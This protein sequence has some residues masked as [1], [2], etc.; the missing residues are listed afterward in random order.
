[1]SRVTAED[2]PN[3]V[4]AQVSRS[5][6]L[7]LVNLINACESLEIPTPAYKLLQLLQKPEIAKAAIR[8]IDDARF[9]VV[10]ELPD[11]FDILENVDTISYAEA[12]S[13]VLRHGY[14]IVSPGITRMLAQD[15]GRNLISLEKS[16]GTGAPVCLQFAANGSLMNVC[17]PGRAKIEPECCIL[18]RK[19][20]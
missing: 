4:F 2:I 5:G 8:A 3:D 7:A 9:V 20:E 10:R 12:E 16:T 14:V 15:S 18:V 1:M 11:G 13:W 6:S 19:A 17:E